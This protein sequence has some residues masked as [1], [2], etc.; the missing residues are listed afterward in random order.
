MFKT[1]K[2]HAQQNTQLLQ[3]TRGKECGNILLKLKYYKYCLGAEVH[4]I[5]SLNEKVLT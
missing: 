1:N 5:K 4:T 2:R 3:Q